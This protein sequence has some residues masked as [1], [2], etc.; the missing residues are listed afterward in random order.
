MKN[1]SENNKTEENTDK[2]S[3]FNEYIIIIILAVL[4]LIMIPI[5]VKSCME[6]QKTEPAIIPRN[7]TN[8]DIDISCNPDFLS[9]G[10]KC[11]ITPKVNINGLE[12]AFEFYEDN[13]KINRISKSVGDVKQDKQYN[14]SLSL[15]EISLDTTF[16]AT[17]YT[18]TVISGTATIF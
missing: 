14:I 1:N 10:I 7:A 17:D 12:I 4:L 5:I 16:N 2:K 15:Y 13:K 11:T 18:V 9:V 8:A 6:S 3:K